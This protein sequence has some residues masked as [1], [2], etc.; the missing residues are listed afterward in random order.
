MKEKAKPLECCFSN[1]HSI[2]YLV[3]LYHCT[4]HCHYSAIDRKTT[5]TG[6]TTVVLLEFL[7]HD[8]TQRG[9]LR[10]H[11]FSYSG[12]RMFH[13]TNKRQLLLRLRI[14]RNMHFGNKLQFLPRRRP[15][16]RDG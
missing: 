4:H 13:L 7:E 8:H 1:R 3:S 5:M 12:F 14:T 9:V 16:L 10:K 11:S 2:P 15:Q 6:L